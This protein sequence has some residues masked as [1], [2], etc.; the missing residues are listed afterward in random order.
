VL[1]CSGTRILEAPPAF[2]RHSISA[3]LAPN[4]EKFVHGICWRA[5][6]SHEAAIASEPQD[7]G[8]DV[9]VHI[10]AVEKAGLSGLNE[11]QNVE[12]EV[13]TNR[14]KASAENL[15]VRR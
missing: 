8:K 4:R 12:Y 2:V 3:G 14:G 6:D 10:S 13:I 1:V 5:S 7:G 15:K 9:F 11:G